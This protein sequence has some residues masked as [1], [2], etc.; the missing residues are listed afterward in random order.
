MAKESMKLQGADFLAKELKKFGPEVERKAAIIGVRKGAQIIRRE[1]WRLMRLRTG[2]KDR[3]GQKRQPGSLKKSIGYKVLRKIP[4]AFVGLRKPRSESKGLWYYRTLEF[5][6]QR[7]QAYAPFFEDAVENSKKQAV[8]E[9]MSATLKG[10]YTEAGKVYA[11]SKA[12]QS[13]YG[14]RRG[15]VK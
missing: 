12:D 1:M 3:K 15:R 9:V 6:H 10:I 5:N 11:R 2:S 14:F 13:R 4:V 7:G 8:D